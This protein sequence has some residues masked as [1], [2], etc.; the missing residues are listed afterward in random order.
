MLTEDPQHTHLAAPA[1]VLELYESTNQPL[2]QSTGRSAQPAQGAVAVIRVGD[3]VQVCVVLTLVD[4]RQNVLY[5]SEAMPADELPQ[6]LDEGLNFAESMGLILDSTGWPGLDAG[7]R[8]ELVQ[9]LGAF[10]P[11]GERLQ[12][13]PAERAKTTNPL[14]SVARL[15]AAFA[16]L[17][18]VAALGC[19]GLSAEQRS[20]AAEIHYDLGTNYMT[21]GDAQAALGEYLE[22]LKMEDELAQ[23]HNA[24]GLLYAF[25]LNDARQAE[26]HFKRALEIDESFA[27]AS[28]N[29][30]AFLLG[31]QRWAE[32]V[33]LFEKALANPLYV[34]RAVAET[35]LGWALHRSGKS[36]K[37]VG[38]IRSALLVAP[39]FCK[40]WRQLGSIYSEQ[41]KLPEAVESF[42]RYSVECAEVAD[43][44]M[45]LGKAQA[46]LGQGDAAKSSFIRCTGL[47]KEKD[48]NTSAECARL[49]RELGAP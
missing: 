5:S 7:Q 10:R 11:P 46:R 20:K 41:G 6:G 19:T 31:Q 14:A 40:G 28:N 3:Q 29:Y 27:E 15:F 1:D 38:R 4:A 13:A 23:V 37:G 49:L 21:H 9:R 36:D 33:P 26:V 48:P 42:E 8:H 12:A 47:A 30:G 39:K 22:A 18:G 35:N 43:A 44:W 45:M 24:L 16:L 32:A 34:Q 25:S 17:L 2:V